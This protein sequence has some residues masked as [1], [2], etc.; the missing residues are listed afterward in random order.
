[1]KKKPGIST[2]LPVATQDADCIVLVTDHLL[3]K[4]IIPTQI[5]NMRSKNLVDTRN[6]LDHQVWRHAGFMVSVLG[7]KSSIEKTE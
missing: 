4:D 6:M 7:R 1:M 3:F 2:K 5:T